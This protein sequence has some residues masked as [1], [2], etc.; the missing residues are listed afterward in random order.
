MAARPAHAPTL[1]A[2]AEHLGVSRTTVSNAYNRPDQLSPTLRERVLSAARELGYT[3]PDPVARSLRRGKAGSLGL[4]FDH[5]LRYIFDDPAA[6]LFLSGVAAGCEEQGTGL[7]LVP[8]LP[9][10]AAELVRSALVDGYVLFCT[11]END[12]RLEAVRARGLPYV[13]VD[14][15]PYVDGPRV[16]IDD[17]GGASAV[18]QHLVDLGHR[19]FGLVVPYEDGATDAATATEISDPTRSDDRTRWRCYIRHERLLGWRDPIVAAGIDWAGV[20]VGSSPE[21]D[22]ES[23]YRAAAA[24]LDR[25]DRPT[26]IVCLSDV[27]ALGVIRAAQERGIRIPQDLSVVGYDDIA[28]AAAAK[29]T[30]VFQPHAAKGEEAVRLLTDGGEDVVLPTDLVV[31]ASSGPAPS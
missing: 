8:Q 22:A 23:G 1:A 31:R 11:P 2:V 10:G 13:L 3:G 17:R 15:S 28:A 20:P 25:A 9:E 7:A 27:L 21:G 6:V 29:L 18:A 19:R 26:A 30:T 5:R 14:F 12:E 16:N 24:L 4:V